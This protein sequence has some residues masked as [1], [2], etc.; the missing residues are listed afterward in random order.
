MVVREAVVVVG[1]TGAA[2]VV[3][4]GCELHPATATLATRRA[5]ASGRLGRM[6]TP[7]AGAPR[8]ERLVIS[9]D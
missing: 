8:L 9:L 7:V 2:A 6:M 5:V 4:T 3:G 1:G